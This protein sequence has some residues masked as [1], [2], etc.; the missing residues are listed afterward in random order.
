VTEFKLS[1]SG[2]KTVVSNPKEQSHQLLDSLL[3]LDEAA[4]PVSVNVGQVRPQGSGLTLI[5]SLSAT[6]DMTTIKD[7]QDVLAK[8]LVDLGFEPDVEEATQNIQITN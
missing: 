8:S 7:E 3:T 6:A 5:V 1:Y 2:E 4:T